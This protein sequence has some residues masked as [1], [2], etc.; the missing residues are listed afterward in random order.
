MALMNYLLRNILISL[1]DMAKNMPRALLAS[2]G[3]IFL[4]ASMIAYLSLRHA[5]Q[6]YIGG[7]LFGSLQINEMIVSMPAVES[8]GLLE[9]G[10]SAAG[11][12]AAKVRRIMGMEGVARFQPVIRLDLPA[13]VKAEM[14]GRVMREQVPVY[15]VKREFL[16]KTIRNWRGFAAGKELPVVV[17]KFALEVFNSMIAG[18]GLPR[19]G[20]GLLVGFPVDIEIRTTPRG[21]P[22][23]KVY[24]FTA[25][26][27]G[28]TQALPVTGLILPYDFIVRFC[29]A[30][31]GD[32][33]E[34]PRG[35]SYAKLFLTV[36]DVKDI[37]RIAG[38][39]GRMGLAVESQQD[40]AAKTNRAMMIIDGSSL[41]ILGIF[42]LL[43]VI[44]IVNSYLTIVYHRSRRFSLLRIVGMSKFRI[45]MSF[46]AEAAFIGAVY[47]A[48]GCLGGLTLM[49]IVAENLVR[50]V[51]ALSGL[52]FALDW[53]RGELLAI[54][55]GISA[56]V[57]SAS[58]LVPAIIASN[59]NLFKAV[60]R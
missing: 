33:K 12:P 6:E 41:V 14:L 19:F 22:D 52:S 51:P 57:S 38:E 46:V 53:G 34:R 37:P 43:T 35:Y 25:K 4:I 42:L 13:R 45:I 50:W 1:R 11:I 47:G 32:S 39:I 58:A 29:D 36:K 7:N 21:D 15:G 5:V 30:H 18:R 56:L 59:M 9:L 10:P 48:V 23:K 40:I 20:E 55:A 16:R 31:R 26:V 3:I 8:A 54:S 17:P 27:F 60:Q 28:F 44:A 49:D 24:S 2:F